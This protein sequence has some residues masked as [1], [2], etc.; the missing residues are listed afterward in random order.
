MSFAKFAQLGA[1]CGTCCSSPSKG[2]LEREF[3]GK[4]QVKGVKRKNIFKSQVPYE[5]HS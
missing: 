3:E 4:L 1:N 5:S 2:F